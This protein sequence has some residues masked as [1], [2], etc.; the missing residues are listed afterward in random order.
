[1]FKNFFLGL[2]ALFFVSTATKAQQS[3][4]DTMLWKIEGNELE[5]PSYLF[6]T[7]HASC[8]VNISDK[9][10]KA[11]GE[12]TALV[13]EVDLNDM[14]S[15]MSQ[16]AI[17]AMMIGGGK[18]WKD[19]LTEEEY[20]E[21]KAF[22]ADFESVNVAMVQMMKPN[23]VSAMLVKDLVSCNLDAYETQLNSY[24]KKKEL[25]ILGLETMMEQLQM[26]SGE[27]LESQFENFVEMTALPKEEHEQMMTDMMRLYDEERL[28]ELYE[29]ITAENAINDM[30]DQ[31]RMLD[32]RNIDWIPKLNVIM[33][34]QPA[35]V[36]VGAGHLAGE[37]GV[38]NLLKE[39][40][41][42]LTPIMD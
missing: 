7:I 25:K 13:M 36:A 41:Y 17:S 5:Q 14:S 28:V 6:G 30:I 21:V 1:M 9:I 12:V 3:L 18:T 2:L 31:Q 11:L 38:I 33:T 19:H 23:L 35:F 26:L 40:G 22:F 37:K 42:T 29:F 8:S 27:D 24:A 34:E 10:K 15:M 4:P 39:A 16:D 32:D 20:K